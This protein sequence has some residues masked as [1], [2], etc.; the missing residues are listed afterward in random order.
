MNE[1]C[2]KVQS[3]RKVPYINQVEE[4][5]LN[6]AVDRRRIR[7]KPFINCEKLIARRR[8]DSECTTCAIIFH[9]GKLKI[10]DDVWRL[11][12]SADYCEYPFV[13][14]ASLSEAEKYFTFELPPYAQS[15]TET[16]NT[17]GTL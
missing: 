14:Y 8:D 10:G 2:N 6:M 3:W 12:C 16:I 17:G 9:S 4:E 11:S 5:C 15:I 1:S 13:S 7:K